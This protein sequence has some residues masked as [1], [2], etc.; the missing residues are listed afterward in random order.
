MSRLAQYQQQVQE[1]FGYEDFQ[2]IPNGTELVCVIESAAWETLLNNRVKPARNDE[3]IKV[4]YRVV[5]GDYDNRVIFQKLHILGKVDQNAEKNE[6]TEENALL[7]LAALD[8]ICLSGAMAKLEHDPEDE[9]LAKLM[10]KKVLV[11]TGINR[12][13]NDFG[14]SQATNFVRFI[15]PVPS[16]RT[17]RGSDSDEGATE[18]PRRERRERRA[19]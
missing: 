5:G 18:R 1:G 2:P 14:E 6:K 15:A 19:R 12:F 7:M 8:H 17:A 4:R 11:T 10:A 9:D 16:Q 13:K 3:F